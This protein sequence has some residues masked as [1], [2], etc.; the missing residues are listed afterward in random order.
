MQPQAREEHPIQAGL[1]TSWSSSRKAPGF[2][3]D[4][5]SSH[6]QKSQAFHLG[7]TG[8]NYIKGVEGPKLGLSTFSL[9]SWFPVSMPSVD[10]AGCSSHM[11]CWCP[12]ADQLW[13][14]GNWLFWQVNPFDG[15]YLMVETRLRTE[16]HIKKR[17]SMKIGFALPGMGQP[18]WNCSSSIF[19]H[20]GGK[21]S[22]GTKSS[23]HDT[24]EHPNL[25]RSSPA[26]GAS[27]KSIRLQEA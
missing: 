6:H 14:S 17:I 9:P 3:T 24:Y 10:G 16:P 13:A 19:V 15:G 1:E 20:V 23:T 4:A 18:G 11:S 8:T 27:D 25:T 5:A 7:V 22:T 2:E 26:A 12:S 21:I